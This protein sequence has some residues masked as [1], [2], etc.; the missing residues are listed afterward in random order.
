MKFL[1]TKT[2]LVLFVSLGLLLGSTVIATADGEKNYFNELANVFKTMSQDMQKLGNQAQDYSKKKEA[3]SELEGEAKK[4]KENAFQM[5]KKVISLTSEAPNASFHS[6]VVNNVS[7][8]YLATRLWEEGLKE[9]DNKK[10]S[11]MEQ[12]VHVVS[13]DSKEFVQEV[14]SKTDQDEG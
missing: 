4:H 12:V 10:L 11:A 6:K 2:S 9:G 1:N 3:K 8:W 7:D 13:K 14:S 5:L